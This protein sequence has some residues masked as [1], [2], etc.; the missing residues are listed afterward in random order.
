MKKWF[1]HLK[2]TWYGVLPLLLLVGVPI[3]VCIVI[4]AICNRDDI[5][6]MISCVSD[7]GNGSLIYGV[8]LALFS[9]IGLINAVA[10]FMMWFRAFTEW[11]GRKAKSRFWF[12]FALIVVTFGWYALFKLIKLL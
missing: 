12:C 9:L 8:I 3:A 2:E 1:E 5:P 6:M 7:I 11:F 10:A 4:W